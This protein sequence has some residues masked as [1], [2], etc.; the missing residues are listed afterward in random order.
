MFTATA[1]THVHNHNQKVHVPLFISFSIVPTLHI[2]Q[3]QTFPQSKIFCSHL[4]IQQCKC[5]W[6]SKPRP[7][8]SDT[9][10]PNSV[11]IFF[12]GFSTGFSTVERLSL[13]FF[14]L[15]LWTE[16]IFSTTW[17]AMDVVRWISHGLSQENVFQKLIYLFI[18]SLLC[19]YCI[20]LNW[21]QSISPCLGWTAKL[22]SLY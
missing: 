16:I 4:L 18:H 7:D 12:V 22:F 14:I 1:A 19:H 3:I 20:F 5:D 2:S 11:F 13:F 17:T 9:A 6:I 10:D 21:T 15:R 8:L